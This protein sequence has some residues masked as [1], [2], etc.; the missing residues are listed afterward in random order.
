VQELLTKT[1][2]VATVLSSKQGKMAGLNPTSA[3]VAQT[4][5]AEQD[6]R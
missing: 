1:A 2:P 4:A 5:G 6:L 3:L